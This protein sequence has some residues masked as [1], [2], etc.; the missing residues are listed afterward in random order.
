MTK[1]TSKTM[2]MKKNKGY[3]FATATAKMIIFKER[4]NK[5]MMRMKN[6]WGWMFCQYWM[7]TEM[8]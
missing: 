2:M 8:L 4:R 5:K 7:E 1:K 3:T 6:L